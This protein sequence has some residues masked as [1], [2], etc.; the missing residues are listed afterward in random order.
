LRPCLPHPLCPVATLADVT[1]ARVRAAISAAREWEAKARACATELHAS[2]GDRPV[3]D[4]AAERAR[5]LIKEAQG[6]GVRMDIEVGLLQVRNGGGA[7]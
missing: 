7:E 5:A 4:A 6:L 2:R 1:A 3:F